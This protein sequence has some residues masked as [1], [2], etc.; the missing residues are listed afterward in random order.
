M[1]D[2]EAFDRRIAREVLRAAG[3]SKPVDDLAIFDAITAATGWQEWGLT[4]FSAVRFL[5][6]A[7]IVA[8]FGGFLLTSILSR[9]Q[10]DDVVPAAASPVPA[11]LVT[12]DDSCGCAASTLTYDADGVARGR[13][14]LDCE[15]RASDPRFAGTVEGTVDSE[16][17]LM[18][19]LMRDCI[20]SGTAT[21]TTD[22][23]AWDCT[24]AGPQEP[25]GRNKAVLLHAC[26]G[27][28]D[29]A[30]LSYMG[31]WAWP[32]IDASG[33]IGD[34]SSHR[35]IIYEGDLPP[36]FESGPR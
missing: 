32:I 19:D 2:V 10:G 8:L 12:G 26:S 28:G 6:A 25:D 5:A 14:T 20:F 29:Y 33:D 35:G 13:G 16:C 27:V 17:H 4:L 21:M 7:A 23:G 3:P 22:D 18:P 9:Q 30:G 31:H 24:F 15:M 34:G 11:V 1:D 36:L